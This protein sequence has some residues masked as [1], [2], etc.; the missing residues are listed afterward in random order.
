MRGKTMATPEHLE[1]LADRIDHEQLW[2][3]AAMYRDDFTQDQRD[4]L[5]A[6]VQL[7]RYARDKR[8]EQAIYEAALMVPNAGIHRAAEGRPVE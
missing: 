4:R 1:A 5:D 8:K 3:K 6:G 7:R 2:R